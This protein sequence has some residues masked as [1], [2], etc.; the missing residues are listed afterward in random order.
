MK[1]NPY[2]GSFRHSPPT[3]LR[4][5]EAELGSSHNYNFSSAPQTLRNSPYIGWFR[6]APPISIWIHKI[7]QKH[8]A[9]LDKCQALAMILDSIPGPEKTRPEL[10]DIIN[11]RLRGGGKD[12]RYTVRSLDSTS[13]AHSVH[14]VLQESSNSSSSATVKLLAKLGGW[15]LFPLA[16]DVDSGGYKEYDCGKGLRLF[17]DTI[18]ESDSEDDSESDSGDD[19]SSIALSDFD[20]PVT[21]PITTTEESPPKETLDVSMSEIAQAY[22]AHQVI[23]QS[24]YSS[25]EGHRLDYVITQMDIARMARNASRHL[26]VDSILNL[27]TVT[28]RS[29]T[30][31]VPKQESR[32]V[33]D[34]RDPGEAWSFIMVPQIERSAEQAA[35]DTSNDGC[36]ICLEQFKDGE[37]LRVLPCDHS[38]HVGCI[39]RWLSGS[40]SHFECFTSGCPTCKTRPDD[41]PISND[42]SVPSWA[43]ARLGAELARSPS[44]VNE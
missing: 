12:K 32:Y 22:H 41:A 21:R 16:Y 20:A 9:F 44:S 29:P 35:P 25:L 27:P 33:E 30:P 24:E 40:H 8:L 10:A 38:F 18:V 11:G 39:D 7:D 2:V 23:D 19:E 14:S 15:F 4:S 42:G 37:R 31:A 3:S 17:Q 36:V 28:Y 6:H 43:F 5:M 13:F 26:D 1:T 34:S